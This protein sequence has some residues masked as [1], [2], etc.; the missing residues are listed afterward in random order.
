[1][2]FNLWY[3]L[4]VNVMVSARMRYRIFT[5]DNFTCQYCGRSVAD[6]ENIKLEVEH[7]KPQSRG[8]TD[9]FN[10]LVTACFACNRGK[11]ADDPVLFTMNHIKP[12]TKQNKKTNFNFNDY[13]NYEDFLTKTG[14]TLDEGIKFLDKE[15]DKLRKNPGIKKEK[16]KYD[17]WTTEDLIAECK[18]RGILEKKDVQQKAI[19]IMDKHNPDFD[20]LTFE[21]KRNVMVEMGILELKP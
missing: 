19:A 17:D 11:H 20:N 7:V 1:V 8:G 3:N 10:N 16:T 6:D 2:A 4:G 18:R 5:R 12:K 9:A 13:K 15:L 21:Q 14:F